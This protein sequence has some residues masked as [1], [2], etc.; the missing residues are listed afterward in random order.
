MDAISNLKTMAG[1]PDA[2]FES[3]SRNLAHGFFVSGVR[4]F[5][6]S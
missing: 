1:S 6:H 4:S 2:D 3:A 5:E